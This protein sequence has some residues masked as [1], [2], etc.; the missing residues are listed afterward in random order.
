M[1]KKSSLHNLR[2]VH[3]EIATAFIGYS[4]SPN[5]NDS[6]KL[7]PS[8]KIFCINSFPSALQL[9][10]LTSPFTIDNNIMGYLLREK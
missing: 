2:I 6:P 9:F 10:S 7:C 4:L 8:T 5:S 3:G 1:L